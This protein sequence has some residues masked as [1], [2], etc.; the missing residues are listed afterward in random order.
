MAAVVFLVPSLSCQ[1]HLSKLQLSQS[2]LSLSIKPSLCP[3]FSGG[4]AQGE[5]W[6]LLAILSKMSDPQGCPGG[7]EALDCSWKQ[8]EMWQRADAVSV[9]V[10]ECAPVRGTGQVPVFTQSNPI[11]LP[12]SEGTSW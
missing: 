10:P 9:P 6:D 4:P 5:G 2:L 3:W 12:G 11:P 8:E 1:P 7:K